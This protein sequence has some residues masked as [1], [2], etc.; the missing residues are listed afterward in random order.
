MTMRGQKLSQ[1]LRHGRIGRVRQAELLKARASFLRLGIQRH[2]GKEAVDQQRLNFVSR[3]RQLLAAA[4]QPRAAA[5][6][7]QRPFVGRVPRHQDFLQLTATPDENAPLPRLQM[8]VPLD[9]LLQMMGQRQIEI[10]APQNQMI[11]DRHAMKLHDSIVT[12]AHADQCEVCRAAANVADQ[13]LLTGRHQ[14]IPRLRMLINPGVKRGLRF[15]NQDD[16]VQAGLSSGLHGQLARHFIE[17]GR[18]RQHEVLFS[19]RMPGKL[20]VPRLAEMQQIP[21]TDRDGRQPSDVF[22]PLPRQQLGR[23]IDSVVTEPRLGRG[24][25]PAR[26]QSPMIPREMTDEVPRVRSLPR[27]TDRSGG[28]L[29]TRRLVVKRRQR[30]AGFDLSR[31]DD[32]RDG[33]RVDAP[34][35]LVGVD[36]RHRGVRRPQVES[37][38]KAAGCGRSLVGADHRVLIFF[39]MPWHHMSSG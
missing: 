30:V 6:K 25:H 22:G 1:V 4:N 5:G 26:H 34:R 27:Q 29:A 7:R 21:G 19:Q 8:S 36:I 39:A 14:P 12:L 38:N 35:L 33:E 23:A 17:R 37:H 16:A 32:L 13:D 9:P 18:E 15:L 20:R 31:R 11:A 3:H 28:K 2:V 10:V 24:D